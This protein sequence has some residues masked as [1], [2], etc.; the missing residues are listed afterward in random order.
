MIEVDLELKLVCI[1]FFFFF[2][3]SS[4]LSFVLT[5]TKIYHYSN[6]L[7][8]LTSFWQIFNLIILIPFALLLSFHHFNSLAISAFVFVAINFYGILRLQKHKKR[9]IISLN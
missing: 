4:A 6:I 9:K 5:F 1:Y 7:R 3:I 8:Q 2:M